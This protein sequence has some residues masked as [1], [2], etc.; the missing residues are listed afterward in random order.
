MLRLLFRARDFQQY[1]VGALMPSAARDSYFVMVRSFPCHSLSF[2][3]ILWPFNSITSA[4]PWLPLF[5][6]SLA[7]NQRAFNIEVAS[8]KDAAN[9]NY[10]AAQ[11]RFAFWH[12]VVANAADLGSASN[13][14]SAAHG[15][16]DA[17][18]GAAAAHPLTQALAIVKSRHN[19][20]LRFLDRLIDAR[21]RGSVWLAPLKNE[22]PQLTPLAMLGVASAA[23]AASVQQQE[24]EDSL[25][26]GA[27]CFGTMLAL[28]S[29]ADATQGSLLYL[30]LEALGVRD[31][32]ADHAARYTIH[33]H[34]D[35]L[36]VC[37]RGQTKLLTPPNCL[38]PHRA[39]NNHDHA[40]QSPTT[41]RSIEAA[42]PASR[43][44]ATGQSHALP[45]S[46]RAASP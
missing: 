46:Q 41:S 14:D 3:V 45:R 39:S 44:A 19:H 36:C 15:D 38:Q 31:D 8:I 18:A 5:P 22:A 13:G 17:G 10:N 28:E 12:D 33:T 37:A 42:V 21:V 1:L 23:A 34:T 35:A 25:V 29:Y 4:V 7:N 2:P 27:P 16:R 20:T 9:G 6:A 43:R 40:A 32:S 11:P 24:F 30:A 26:A